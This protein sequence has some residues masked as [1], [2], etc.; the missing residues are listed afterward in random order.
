MSAYT[1]E[2]LASASGTLFGMHLQ[3]DGKIVF[4]HAGHLGELLAHMGRPNPDTLFARIRHL[5]AVLEDLP[6]QHLLGRTRVA[7][8]L[9]R[10][11]V[12]VQALAV[13]EP[14]FS[15]RELADRAGDPGLVARLSSNP[16]VAPPATQQML[17]ELVN[18]LV[19]VVGELE[20]NRHGSLRNLAVAEWG[21]DHD[22]ATLGTLALAGEGPEFDYTALSKV[23]L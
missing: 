19:Q 6:G 23:H 9:L 16:E 2:Q 7:R 8:Y 18:R 13:G 22:R 3:R 11:A 4:D 20:P 10:T 12:Y 14:C 15:L 21:E 5:G 1:P 17:D